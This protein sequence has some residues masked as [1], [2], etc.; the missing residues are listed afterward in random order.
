MRFWKSA[1]TLL[2]LTVIARGA[3]AFT[4]ESGLW[5]NPA[6]DGRGYAIEIQ[7]STLAILVYAYDND[8]ARTSAFFTGAGTMPNN[9]SFSGTLSGATNGQ[10]LT[11]TYQGRPVILTGSGGAVAIA[12]DTETRARL[13][14]GGRTI[15]IER[16]N[17]ALGN[18]TE[19]MQGEW[20]V[21]LDFA[22]A[23]T[24]TPANNSPYFGEILS[25]DRVDTSFNP[26]Q[27]RGC[28][29]STSLRRCGALD[30][31]N[32]DVAGF[33]DA[34]T[35]TQTIVVTDRVDGTDTYFLVYYVTAGLSQFDGVVAIRR[36]NAITDACS[37]VR[38]A[39][40]YPVR[41]FRSASKRFV[42]TGSGPNSV[43]PLAK[44]LPTS[45]ARPGVI[46]T[47]GGI[48]DLPEGL[49]SDQVKAQ[50]GID[51]QALEPRVRALIESM[52]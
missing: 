38:G 34:E 20:Q 4:P 11:C 31:A 30:N 36:N 46:E 12:F 49:D 18:Q 10:C 5:W 21:V 28:R 52:R 45:V 39:A 27:Y 23:G 16:F 47:L 24:T 13:T 40:C 17:F 25:I 37:P 19:Q 42:Q 1:L 22:P 26:D 48:E 9:S 2:V 6:E 3:A 14:I 33:F 29:P 41:G 8:T 32:H 50:Y 15:P 35:G 44:S 43:G 7:D 51:V